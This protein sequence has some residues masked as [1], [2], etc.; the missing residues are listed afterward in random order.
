M[1]RI[2]I[3]L[4]FGI[5][6]FAGAVNAAM[7]C[8]AKSYASACANCQ[9]DANG[10]IDQSCSNSFRASGISC[11]STSYPIM[12]GKYA[13]GQCPAV[14]SCADELSSCA[15]Q[16]GTGNDKADCQE[17]SLGVCYAASDECVKRAAMGCGEIESPCPGSSAAFILLL[18]GVG[19]VKLTK[20]E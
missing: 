3:I 15:A 2:A 10:K 8:S 7:D 16:Y 11:V 5:L 12:S 13:A 18:L 9:F 4:V 19:F 6:F 14:D 17:G 20:K 1:T